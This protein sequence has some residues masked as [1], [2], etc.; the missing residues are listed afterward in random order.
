MGKFVTVKMSTECYSPGLAHSYVK[1]QPK[2]PEFS[3][4]LDVFVRDGLDASDACIEVTMCPLFTDI[5]AN[6]ALRRGGRFDKRIL[7]VL[8]P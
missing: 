5:N 8:S 7:G 3:L 6:R 1:S 4:P 2:V